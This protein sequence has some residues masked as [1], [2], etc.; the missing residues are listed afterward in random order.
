MQLF[1]P[2]IMRLADL[3]G[4]VSWDADIAESVKLDMKNLRHSVFVQ[5]S[6]T[7]KWHTFPR[8]LWKQLL[9]TL[10]RIDEMCEGNTFPVGVY[11]FGADDNHDFTLIIDPD[12]MDPMVR[13]GI[14]P[15]IGTKSGLYC[16]N[17]ATGKMR[18][19][20]KMPEHTGID[21]TNAVD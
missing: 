14:R 7:N 1:G 2:N 11:Q 17:R 13:A 20:I 15:Q 5:G 9:K 18:R 8:N 12:D 16:A 4:H 3:V 6:R 10:A 21:P 19:I